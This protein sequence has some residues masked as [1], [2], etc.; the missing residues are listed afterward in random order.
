MGLY[1]L[2]SRSIPDS[3][4]AKL[5]LVAFLGQ[6]L[7]LVGL[8]LYLL[9]SGLGGADPGLIAVICAAV[10][11]GLVLSFLG[12]RALLEPVLLTAGALDSWGRTG[13]MPALPEQ[14]RDEVGILMIRVNRMMARA[15]R[16]LD[17]SRRETDTDPLT[18]ALN[19]RGAERLLRDA[20]TGW[21][22]LIDLDRFGPVNAVHGRAEG[23]RM[24]RDVAR[25]CA[26][27]I[28]QDDLLARV[29]GDE[30]LVFL[31]GAPADIALR[32]A[33]RLRQRLA[34]RLTVSGLTITTSVG[35]AAHPGGRIDATLARAERALVR[36]KEQGRDRLVRDDG[37]GDDLRAA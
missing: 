6:M 20:T 27:V 10:C 2:L 5:F 16:T 29:G 13:Q 15:Q 23:D 30:F 11:A 25:V 18:G 28:R 12:L 31:P 17:H 14:Y 35:L 7:P 32:I 24:L 33:D 8:A 9:P 37:D 26:S 36:A 4:V 21:L 3:F 1:Q 22:M 34:P 19:R